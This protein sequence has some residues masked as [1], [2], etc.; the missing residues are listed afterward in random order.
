M[1][2]GQVV[3]TPT[4]HSKNQ[5]NG[6]LNEL[7]RMFKF[8]MGKGLLEKD[9]SIGIEAKDPARGALVRGP[10]AKSNKAITMFDLYASK[11]V[12]SWLHIHHQMVF[13]TIR[14][15][16]LRISETFGITLGDIY[17]HE[18]QM[19]IHIWRQGGKNFKVLDEH[20]SRKMVTAKD[21]VKTASSIR[22]LPIARPVAELIDL[23]IEAFQ[24]GAR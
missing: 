22:V 10:N 13:W 5:V 20:G 3:T 21:D 2:V 1:P 8:A 16:G 15:V 6:M 19:T 12:A 18:G 11:R 24:D 14:C 9:P 23:Y 17:R 7:R 4:A